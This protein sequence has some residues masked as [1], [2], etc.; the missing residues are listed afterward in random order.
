MSEEENQLLTVEEVARLLRVPK[1][2]VYERSRARSPE[3]F[4]HIKLGK[5]LRFYKADVQQYLERMRREELA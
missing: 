5:Y 1:S 4:P 2:W 3:R